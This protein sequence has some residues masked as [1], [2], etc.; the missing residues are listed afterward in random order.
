MQLLHSEFPYVGGKF[1]I[2]FY[3]C[4]AGHHYQEKYICASGSF[5]LLANEK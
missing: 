3:K 4:I 5:G 1:D 2:L